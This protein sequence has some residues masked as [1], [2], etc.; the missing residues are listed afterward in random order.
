MDDDTIVRPAGFFD[1]AIRRDNRGVL[2]PQLSAPPR[3]TYRGHGILYSLF[4]SA[5][6]VIR[7]PGLAR[8]IARLVHVNAG[9]FRRG[10]R[11]TLPLL[12]PLFPCEFSQQDPCPDLE[13]RSAPRWYQ[14]ILLLSFRRG[15]FQL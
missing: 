14:W 13:S 2:S 1:E 3:G 10:R 9:D 15:L 12:Q 6:F 7:S 8:V 11:A 4:C 5:L